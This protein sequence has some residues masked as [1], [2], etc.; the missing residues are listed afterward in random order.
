MRLLFCILLFLA[1]VCLGVR[2][3]YDC[4]RKPILLHSLADSLSVLQNEICASR[5]P[6]P[7][8]LLR[9]TELSELTRS[10]YQMLYAGLQTDLPFIQ[11]WN[12]AVIKFTPCSGEA[13]QS[14][15]MLGQQIGRYDA[16]IQNSAFSVCILFLREYAS[17]ER[18]MSKTNARMSVGL[19]AAF[20]LLL[21]IA[22]Y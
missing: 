21:A 1:S 10:F 2:N 16:Q 13:R 17:K 6:L 14:L 20:G 15:L 22:C 3:A 7:A 8:A 18:T 19:G 12:S 11:T 4:S 5:K 9:C